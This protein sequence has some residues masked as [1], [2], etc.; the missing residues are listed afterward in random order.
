MPRT[1][2]QTSSTI[3]R[4]IPMPETSTQKNSWARS[5]FTFHTRLDYPNRFHLTTPYDIK[6]FVT[7]VSTI[8]ATARGTF[9]S[10]YHH[11]F[12]LWHTLA[13]KQKIIQKT[14]THQLKHGGLPRRLENANVF[15]LGNKN[16][17]PQ[18]HS[19][20]TAPTEDWSEPFQCGGLF[21]YRA[22]C[23]K[24]SGHSVTLP[25]LPRAFAISV[26]R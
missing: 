11:P 22:K 19:F 16:F 25:P 1:I 26:G 13:L 24:F 7:L 5:K 20:P 23:Y 21:A 14:H 17:V 8:S 18:S 9:R 4:P 3:G 10:F 6:L 2:K 12:S 15:K